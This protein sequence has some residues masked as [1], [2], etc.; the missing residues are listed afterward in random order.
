[1]TEAGQFLYPS[2][3]G[4]KWQVFVDAKPAARDDPSTA[5][6]KDL[7]RLLRAEEQKLWRGQLTPRDYVPPSSRASSRCSPS[8]T[9]RAVTA[10][11]RVLRRERGAPGGRRGAQRPA[12]MADQHNAP[13]RGLAGDPLVRRRTWTPWRATPPSSTARTRPPRSASPPGRACSPGATPTPTARSTNRLP[14]RQGERPSGTWR[15]RRDGHR[16]HRQDA[17][18]GP[19]RHQGFAIRWDYDDYAQAEPEAAGT[20]PRAWPPGATGC[21]R[22]APAPVLPATNRLQHRPRN[23]VAAPLALP[24][25][26]AHRGLH[27]P[28]GRALLGGPPSRA[29]GALVSYFKPHV[30]APPRL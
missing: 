7:D 14:L 9:G 30:P 13:R 18:R 17:L 29:L 12:V 6:F 28:G 26:A 21:A 3:P 19:D 15:R 27:H 23:Y 4:L 10:V 2:L 22:R 24:R 11:G 16:G 25:R 20:P 5:A 1:M 8:R